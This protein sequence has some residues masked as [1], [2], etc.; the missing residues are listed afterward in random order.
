MIMKT[1]VGAPASDRGRVLIGSGLKRLMTRLQA[2]DDLA[3]GRLATFNA[4]GNPDATQRAASQRQ[5]R[6]T[7]ECRF[8]FGNAVSVPDTVLRHRVG[9]PHDMP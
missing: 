4:T 1:R 5:G 8:D 6:Q 7:I 9:V 3:C 2:R